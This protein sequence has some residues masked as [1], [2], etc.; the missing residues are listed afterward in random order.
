MRNAKGK[1]PEDYGFSLETIFIHRNALFDIKKADLNTILTNAHDY[2]E[3][4][5]IEL[6][7]EEFKEKLG[8]EIKND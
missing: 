6:I 7:T 2:L 8:M 4:Y 3:Q 5:F 1:K